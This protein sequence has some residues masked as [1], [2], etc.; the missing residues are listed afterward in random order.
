MSFSNCA[1]FRLRPTLPAAFLLIIW[2]YLLVHKETFVVR[3]PQFLSSA[4]PDL[5]CATLYQLI[6]LLPCASCVFL[7]W[8]LQIQQ[9]LGLA[10]GSS[11]AVPRHGGGGS[12]HPLLQPAAARFIQPVGECEA[13]VSFILESLTKDYW[14]VPA[15]SRC[16][17]LLLSPL[18]S[19]F[20]PASSTL[21]AFT[22]FAYT[23]PSHHRIPRWCHIHL[24]PIHR[25]GL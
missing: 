8:G 16:A 3:A 22:P 23:Q 2:D 4:A 17:L 10:P 6:S 25:E 5:Q 12:R 19:G 21:W 13:K 18:L 9:Q 20:S 1:L 14:P 15:D 24:G 11:C 7:F